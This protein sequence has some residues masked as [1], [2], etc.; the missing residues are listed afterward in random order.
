MNHSGFKCMNA[1][2]HIFK[3]KVFDQIYSRVYTIVYK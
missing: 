1:V 2:R 3:I